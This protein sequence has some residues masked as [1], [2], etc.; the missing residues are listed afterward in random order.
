M[1]CLF[2]HPSPHHF[3]FFNSVT[4]WF[5]GGLDICFHC[6]SSFLLKSWK[7][8]RIRSYLNNCKLCELGRKTGVMLAW[9][10]FFSFL[11]PMKI[12]LASSLRV[13]H[14]W[15]HFFLNGN[16]FVSLTLLKA[17]TPWL[18]P[19]NPREGVLFPPCAWSFA[20]LASSEHMLCPAHV[21][22]SAHTVTAVPRPVCGC[23]CLC[24]GQG[25]ECPAPGVHSLAENRGEQQRPW[26]SYN[27]LQLVQP[28][29]H[30]W[31]AVL[32]PGTTLCSNTPVC[33]RDYSEYQ[34]LVGSKKGL[35]EE[36]PVPGWGGAE[37]QA[38]LWGAPPC[39]ESLPLAL[40]QAHLPFAVVGSTEEVKVGNKLVRA[41]QYPWG[42][43][44]GEGLQAHPKPPRVCSG[45]PWHLPSSAL[46]Q[47][48][49]MK[50][51]PDKQ[52]RHVPCCLLWVD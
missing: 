31:S 37:V 4:S 51:P 33:S 47:H 29:Q 21:P 35:V 40:F 2:F 34:R 8:W 23:P 6:N 19:C 20:N 25:R 12:Y 52:Y 49:C 24:F 5:L 45:K 9:L 42:V 48:L 1:L 16:N 28:R 46:H 14:F 44:Q 50:V 43:V 11:P 22:C 41:R 32:G 15:F 10:F 38:D 7:I 26:C 18:L 17:P 13:P 27:I 3:F 30:C 36:A 39:T